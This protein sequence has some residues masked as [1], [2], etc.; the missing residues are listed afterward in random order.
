[1]TDGGK[2]RIAV[3]ETTMGTIS[4]ELDNNMPITAG[5]FEKLVKAGIL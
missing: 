3:L 4:I 1:M 5:N 2:P